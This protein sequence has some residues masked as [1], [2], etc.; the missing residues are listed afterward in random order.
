MTFELFDPDQPVDITYRRLPHW[1]QPGVTY[2]ITFRTIDSMPAEVLDRWYAERKEWLQ[3]H[4][5]DP[6]IEDW[7]IA[8]RGLPAALQSQ[9]H[10]RFSAAYHAALDK[11]HGECLLRRPQLARIVADSLLHFDGDRYHMA[12]FVIMPNHVHLLA[13]LLG[14]TEPTSQCKSWKH[15]TATKIHK[16]LG[17][18]GHFWQPEGFDHLVRSPEQFAHFQWYLSENPRKAH[19]REGEYLLYQKAEK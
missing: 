14:D 1:Y 2:F 3:Q 8:F 18:S 17:R 15:Y 16:A 12:V 11:G 13:C 5:I 19:L 9:F 4:R 6:A 7:Q 10:R